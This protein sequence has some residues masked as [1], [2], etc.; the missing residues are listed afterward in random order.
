[1][2]LKFAEFK[3]GEDEILKGCGASN[4]Q[5][6]TVRERIFYHTIKQ[7]S[8][9]YNQ[10]DLDEPDNI[11]GHLRTKTGI[12]EDMVNEVDNHLEYD[13][14]LLMFMKYS[15][16]I[17]EMF[18]LYMMLEKAKEMD[19]N[20]YNMMMKRLKSANRELLEKA[21]EQGKDEDDPEVIAMLPTNMVKRIEI[22]A[23]SDGTFSDYLKMYGELKIENIHSD[24][25]DILKNIQFDV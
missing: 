17:S 24:V 8:T 19:Q 13:L 4:Q 23:K 18:K 12:L 14:C 22:Y 20:A 5:F 7:Y 25:D 6:I 1:M 15:T 3:H 16:A 21:E 2:Y 9:V 10:Y 11:P